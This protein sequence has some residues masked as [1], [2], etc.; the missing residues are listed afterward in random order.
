MLFERG[1]FTA[2]DSAATALALAIY[3]L[4]LPAFVLQ[5]VLQPVYFARE[6]TR[7]P[8]YFALV[9]M[10]VNAGAGDRAGAGHRLYRRRHRHHARGLG[11]GARC[12]GSAPRGWARRPGSTRGSGRRLWRIGVAAWAMGAVLWVLALLLGPMFGTPGL[13][14]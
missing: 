2:D 7:T 13:D 11:D 10:V 12:S 1:A 14:R 4:G 6:N 9:S 5:K 8:F 3:G